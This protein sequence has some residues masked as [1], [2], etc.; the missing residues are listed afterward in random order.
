MKH[1]IILLTI[2]VFPL[3]VIAQDTIQSNNLEYYQRRFEHFNQ[4]KKNGNAL[5]IAGSV[6]S[7]AGLTLYL[8]SWESYYYYYDDEAGE[9]ITAV[10]LMII[11]DAAL[12]GG[13]TLS[14]IGKAKS[15][16]YRRL[17]ETNKNTLSLHMTN[18]G[19]TLRFSF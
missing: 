13:I 5:I 10:I 16:Q 17:I 1:I 8:K 3:F 19:L 2:L 11:G 15:D 7:V 6:A 4:M 18:N 14:A 12:A 9:M